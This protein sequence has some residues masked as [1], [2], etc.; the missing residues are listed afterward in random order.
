MAKSRRDWQRLPEGSAERVVQHALWA[1]S[2]GR[3]PSMQFQ[4]AYNPKDALHQATLLSSEPKPKQLMYVWNYL[5]CVPAALYGDKHFGRENY[6]VIVSPNARDN[7][8]ANG[9]MVYHCF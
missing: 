2:R 3:A 1:E 4:G 6:V 9:G 5:Q 7:A 8:L